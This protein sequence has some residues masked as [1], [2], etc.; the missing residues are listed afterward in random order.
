MKKIAL[1][2]STG[3]IGLQTLNVVRRYS[4]KFKVLSLAANSD[5]AGLVKQ[6]AEFKP[7]VVCIRHEK[8]YKD[9]KAALPKEV[10]AVCGQEGLAYAATLGEVDTAVLAL[11]GL[12]GLRLSYSALEAGKHIALANKEALVSGGEILMSLAEKKGLKI[13][14]IDSEHSAIMQCLEGSDNKP[15]RLI[16]TS[17]GG[18]FFNYTRE[19]LSGVT[20]AA[21]LKHP[22]WNMGKKITIDSATMMNKGLEIIE[23]QRLFGMLPEYIVHPQSIIHSM[24]EFWDNSVFAQLSAPDME[25]PIQYALTAPERFKTNLSALNFAEVGKLEFF[26]PREEL[27]PCPRLAYK[28]LE[29]G[30]LA[31]AVLNAANDTAVHAFLEGRLAFLKIPATVEYALEHTDMACGVT[32]DTITD[33]HDAAIEVVEKFIAKNTLC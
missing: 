6:A 26:A 21:A 8:L 33:I 12:E 2:G 31:P 5:V 13:I 25:L 27:F 1:I 10:E 22:T 28:S 4:D 32:V 15:K 3:S 17:S 16:L 24:V 30:G 14:P 29:T 18:P 19:Q 7:R 11:S 9:L 20:P 23:A